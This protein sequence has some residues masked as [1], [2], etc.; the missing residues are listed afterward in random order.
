[1]AREGEV[2]QRQHFCHHGGAI[3]HSK[4]S[5]VTSKLHGTSKCC[6]QTCQCI[7]IHRLLSEIETS[8][9]TIHD[10]EIKLVRSELNMNLPKDV[11]DIV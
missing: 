9:A 10:V 4:S 2:I 11:S 8:M 3:C 6:I 5:Y 7:L 1:M